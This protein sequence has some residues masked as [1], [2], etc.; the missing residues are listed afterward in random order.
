MRYGRRDLPRQQAAGRG[1]GIRRM[2]PAGEEALFILD[3]FQ[4]AVASGAQAK[5]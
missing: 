3:Q 2:A 5:A 1:R 4:R